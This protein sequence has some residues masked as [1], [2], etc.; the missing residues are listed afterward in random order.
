MFEI[1]VELVNI[2]DS[3]ESIYDFNQ[4]F[5]F[6]A[7]I[8]GRKKKDK[9]LGKIYLNMMNDKWKKELQTINKNFGRP[10]DTAKD[11]M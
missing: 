9:E 6:Y 1:Y 4:K 11:V 3:K 7:Q 8:A 5:N 10:L 2:Q